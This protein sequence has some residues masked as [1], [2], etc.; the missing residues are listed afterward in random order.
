MNYRPT[1]WLLHGRGSVLRHGCCVDRYGG[2]QVVQFKDGNWKL[3]GS[4]A[5]DSG[6]IAFVDPSYAE[7]IGNDGIARANDG[8][9]VLSVVAS[10][11]IGDGLFPVFARVNENGCREFRIVCDMV[12]DSAT[13]P[14]TEG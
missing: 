6:L 2:I 7:R 1:M 13:L 4:V 3:I 11:E 12:I 5:V 9:T 8:C 10:T 14:V